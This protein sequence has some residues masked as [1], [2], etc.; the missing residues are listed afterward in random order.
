MIKIKLTAQQQSELK[1]IALTLR[2]TQDQVAFMILCAW[3][4]LGYGD[5][6]DAFHDMVDM[7]LEIRRGETIEW[8]KEWV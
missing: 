7:E 1:R 8:R 6:W 2:V 5:V 4:E 3:M